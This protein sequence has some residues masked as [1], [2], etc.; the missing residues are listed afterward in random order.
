M[1]FF[2]STSI[3][4]AVIACIIAFFC[5]G[6]WLPS[7]TKGIFASP[8]ETAVSVSVSQLLR[9]GSAR[10]AEPLAT[11]IPWLHPRSWVS[12]DDQI[13]PVG[14]LAW[15]FLLA[16]VVGLFG[17]WMLPWFGFLLVSSAFYP[18]LRL[19]RQ[20]FSEEKAVMATLL[21]FFFPTVV[22]YANRGLFANLPQLALF[23]WWLWFWR[24]SEQ[25]AF[26]WQFIILQ[27]MFTALVLLIRPVEGLWLFPWMIWWGR[28]QLRRFSRGQKVAVYAAA[29]ALVGVYALMVARTYGTP[30]AIGYLLRDNPLPSTTMI[31][32][33]VATGDVLPTWQRLLPYGFHP[34]HIWWNLYSFT[35]EILWPWILALLL[36]WVPQIW[37]LRTQKPTLLVKRF[38]MWLRSPRVLLSGW[39]VFVLLVIYGSGIYAD[40]IRPGAITVGNSFLRYLL[41]LL[42]LWGYA[43]FV[44]LEAWDRTARGRIGTKILTVALLVISLFTVFLKDDEG[45]L[46]T[47]RELLRYR[48]IRLAALAALPSGTIVL[49]DRSDKI[50]FPVFRAVSPMPSVTERNRLA[51]LPGVSLALF[52]RPLSQSERD[53]WRTAG[54]VPQEVQSFGN[55]RLYRLVPLVP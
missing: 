40:H 39:T 17:S 44:G 30:F 51:Q 13:A 23:A 45:L 28:D 54:V 29:F 2:R 21:I 25:R 6:A 3:R 15:P 1:P 55:E 42:P 31:A 27:G 41:P 16:P 35:R 20:R 11:Q 24:R 32:P 52:A 5:V 33:V 9:Q 19:W 53:A 22:L 50:F 26:S 10:V 7:A 14:F 37:R 4:F 12:I 8:D 34:R 18:V 48:E 36:V 47:R 49:S 43:L 38:V 46:A